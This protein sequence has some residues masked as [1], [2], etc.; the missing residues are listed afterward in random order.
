MSYQELGVKLRDCF[1]CR[2]Q[3][4]D[5]K[6]YMEK[7]KILGSFVMLKEKKN[8]IVTLLPVLK[9]YSAP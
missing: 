5:S 7:Q 3:Q 2:Y 4:K 8:G 9:I 6:V 1:V